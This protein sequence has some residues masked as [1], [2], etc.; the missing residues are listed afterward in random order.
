[1]NEV[2]CKAVLQ[3]MKEGERITESWLLRHQR[4]IE[5]SDLDS[6]VERG[7]LD[8]YPKDPNDFMSD[9]CYLLTQRG[10]QYAWK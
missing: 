4:G 1:M 2:R 9:T 10:K 6:M 3:M 7:Y 8:K 5:K